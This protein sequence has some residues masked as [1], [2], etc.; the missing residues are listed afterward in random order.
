MAFL[1]RPLSVYSHD[2]DPS[3]RAIGRLHKPVGHVIFN[4]EEF[5]DEEEKF[6]L[7]KKLLDRMRVGTIG[8]YYP[9][10]AYRKEVLKL[11]E[12]VDWDNQS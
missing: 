4:L 6:P 3:N 12:A 7:L 1:N 5:R 9:I 11:M 8:E 2:V 10:E